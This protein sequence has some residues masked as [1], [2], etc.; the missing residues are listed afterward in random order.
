[1]PEKEDQT[2]LATWP[3]LISMFFFKSPLVVIP[4]I[5]ALYYK[6]K[7]KNDIGSSA[8]NFSEAINLPMLS[9]RC[10]SNN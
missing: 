7:E 10:S 1:M 4:S 3:F 5:Q 8:S 6:L 2:F 9:V